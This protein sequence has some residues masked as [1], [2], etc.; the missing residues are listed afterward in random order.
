MK[1]V[2][3][4]RGVV[5]VE[6]VP[7][8]VCEAGGVLVRTAWS[9]PSVG[10]ERTN[11]SGQRV[12][13]RLRR[14]PEVV[15]KIWNGVRRAGLPE[16]VRLVRD[17]ME[18]PIAL[19]NSLSGVVLEVGP[20]VPDLGVGDRVACG[21][22]GHA[23]H[24]EYAF[25]PRNLTARVPDGLD[26]RDA[27]FV[28]LGAI[29]LQGVRRASVQLGETA[30]VVGLGLI[31]LLT[32]QLLRAAGVRVVGIDPR[33]ERTTLAERLGASRAL[34]A[35]AGDPVA[36]V[37]AAT[38]GVGA[39]VVLLTAGTRS[40][41]PVNQ[42]F[43][44]ARERGRVVVVGDVGLQLARPTFYRKELDLVISRSTGPGRYDPSYEQHGLDYPLPYARWTERRNMQEFLRLAADGDLR[45][46]ELVADEFRVDDA[47][48]AYGALDGTA[49]GVAVLLRY[50]AEPHVPG[51]RRIA[52][53]ATGRPRPGATRVA[54]IGAGQFARQTLLPRLVRQRDVALHAIVGGASGTGLH[55]AR[56]F[57][58]SVYSTDA[59]EVLEDPAVDAVVIA[60]RHHLHAP[61]AIEAVRHGKAVFVEKPLALSLADCRAVVEA[62]VA[63]GAVLTVGFNRR[64]APLAVRLRDALAA[65]P[66]PAMAVYRINAGPLPVDHWLLDPVQGGGRILGEGCHFVDLLCWLLGEEPV[67]VQASA[68][69]DGGEGPQQLAMTLQFSGGSVGTIVYTACGH[70]SVAKER[71]EIFTAGR[72]LVLDDFRVL[73]DN[74]RTLRC[75]SGDKGY[76]A[77]VES[78]ARAVRGAGSLAV[79]VMDG[80][81]A[82]AVA[83]RAIEAA[84]AGARLPV[85][86]TRDLCARPER[87]QGG[88]P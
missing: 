38:G 77:E 41:E 51:P 6:E 24:A 5:S 17:K 86:W 48:Q 84:A 87:H 56:R 63:A 36:A 22:I 72:A 3:S 60:T 18:R 45:L 66:G 67:A 69:P 9:L 26:L 49:R 13:D 58:A 85:D 20:G 73:T 33:K 75:R 42:A 11:I 35:D 23:C 39:D 19:G 53:P 62:V 88:Q 29:A 40:N 52:I 78:F 70:P 31:G 55:D 34:V 7:I 4:R 74:G 10:T 27:A 32:V 64:F 15:G 76:D 57:G 82:T 71:I 25:V 47:A 83:L 14:Q 8:P 59:R 61:L 68:P 12:L 65:R 46:S 50:T 43:E 2:F 37:L 81:R 21:G 79:T 28:T 80:V 16:T 54:V 1:Q 30:V 44:M